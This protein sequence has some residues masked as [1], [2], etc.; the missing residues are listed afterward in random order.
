MNILYILW[1]RTTE[2]YLRSRKW[3]LACT[4]LCLVVLFC[5]ACNSTTGTDASATPTPERVN[6]FGTKSN[7]THSLLVLPNGPLL[8]ATHY[9]I[10]RSADSGKTW[11]IVAAGPNQLMQGLMSYSLVASPL[12]AQRLYVVGSP[13]VANPQGTPGLYTSVDQG[14]TWKLVSSVAQLDN[15][16]LAAPGNDNPDEVFIYLNKLG[17][18]GLKV[19]MDGGEHFSTPGT[20]PFGSLASL[21]AVP[22]TPGLLLASGTGGIARST[23]GGAHWQLLKGIDGPVMGGMTTAGPGSPIYASGDAGIYASKDAGQTFTLVN[24]QASYNE[25]TSPRSQPQVVYGKTAT[26]VYRSADGGHTWNPLPPIRI[27]MQN[28]AVDPTNAS[29][30]YLTLNYPTEV[31]R[32]SQESGSW[33]SLTPRP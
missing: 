32:Y 30:L 26:R 4:A 22:G 11:K 20:L 6:G 15:I 17:A 18:L 2:I 16:Y 7:H 25:L 14:L 12:N 31:Y 27:N 24:S 13:A 8:V 19:S 5:S 29:Q 1:S 33:S 21:L 28:L 10:F 3:G 9:G 23:D